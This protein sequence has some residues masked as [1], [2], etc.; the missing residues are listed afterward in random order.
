MTITETKIE[1]LEH[2]KVKLTATV[3]AQDVR[4]EYDAMMR[5]YVSSVRIDGFRKGHV[6]VSVL[7]RKFGE[8]LR[9]DAMG[10]VLE[11]AVEVALKDSEEKPLAY[12]APALEGEPKFVIGEDFTFTVAYDVFPKIVPPSLEGIDIVVPKVSV[13]DEDVA[14]E[15]EQVRQRNA[16]VVDKSGPALKGDI[17][18]LSWNELDAEGK[19][20]PASAREDFTFEVGTGHNLYKFD[21]DIAGLQAG[22]TKTFTKTFAP[23]YEYKELAG[24]SLTLEAKVTKVKQKNL[25]DLD[26]ELAQDVSENYKTLADLTN[27]VKAQLEASLAAKL[28]EVKEKALLQTLVTRTELD[29]PESMVGAELSMRWES[30]KREMGIESDEQMERIAAYSGKTREQLLQDWRPAVEKAIKGRLVMDK[31]LEAGS[32]DVT[33]EELAAEYGRQAK[34]SAL[35]VEE[36]KAEYEKN[37]SVDYLKE[38]IKEGKFIDSVLATASIKEGESAAFVDFV[39]RNE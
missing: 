13:T 4:A 20:I 7:E 15:L 2:S 21:D 23:D 33:E 36:V 11:K 18:T 26:D 6:P 35:S 32:F 17:V 27:A 19:P 14:R 1:K 10:R 34:D 31:L 5:E 28:K 38:R 16:I 8:S 37:Q 39:A 3:L 22:E 12:E 24:K 29:L 30:L 9:L 25:P